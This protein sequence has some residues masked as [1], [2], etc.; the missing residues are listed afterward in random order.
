MYQHVKQQKECDTILSDLIDGIARMLPFID[1]V[2]GRSRIE[3][4]K[5][6]LE[7]MLGLIGR[8]L[9]FILEYKSDGVAGTI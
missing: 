1:P 7:E 3:P 5:E 8:A 6:I 4:L 2:M 9:N